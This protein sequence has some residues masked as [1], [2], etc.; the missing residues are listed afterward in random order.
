MRSL[1]HKDLSVNCCFFNVSRFNRK[2]LL[3]I[4]KLNGVGIQ[5]KFYVKRST[6]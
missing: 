4:T 3:K 6:L 2:L 5:G 1:E